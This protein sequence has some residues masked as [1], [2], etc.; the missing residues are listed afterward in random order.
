MTTTTRILPSVPVGNRTSEHLPRFVLFAFFTSVF[1]FTCG[2]K[3]FFASPFSNSWSGSILSA[4]CSGS[5]TGRA[6]TTRENEDDAE[7]ECNYQDDLPVV[8]L[9]LL[10]LERDC[11]GSTRSVRSC[12][13][14]SSPAGTVPAR[15]PIL[16]SLPLSRVPV[17]SA[18]G[19][20]PVLSTSF[21]TAIVPSL[22]L[23]R[24]GTALSLVG[25]VGPVTM[26][27]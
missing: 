17:R 7:E 16:P 19:T 8:R 3:L 9:L 20:V 18:P 2:Q 25:P 13:P 26:R 5:R 21:S 22:A 14:S 24:R 15:T 12:I 23:G 4:A 27:G 11:V 10:V 6:S 1:F